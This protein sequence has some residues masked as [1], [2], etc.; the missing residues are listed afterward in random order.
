MKNNQKLVRLDSLDIGCCF[1]HKNEIFQLVDIDMLDQWADVRNIQTQQIRTIEIYIYVKPINVRVVEL[2]TGRTLPV[3]K[4]NRRLS[5][6]DSDLRRILKNATI[7]E[8]PTHGW[9]YTNNEQYGHAGF[10]ELDDINDF[11]DE[12]EKPFFVFD[13]DVNKWAGIDIDDVLANELENWYDGAGDH[14]VDYDELVN[15]VKQWNKKQH[16]TEYLPNMEKI[17]ILDRERF[18]RFFRSR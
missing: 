2:P 9:V 18:N 15:F 3:K 7:I 8:K 4:I 1:I 17:I 10:F 11:F 14:I 5:M 16:L 13:C 6:D 12:N